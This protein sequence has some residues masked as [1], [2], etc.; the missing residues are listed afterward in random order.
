MRFA[1]RYQPPGA[2]GS[3]GMGSTGV[4][5]DCDYAKVLA[6][7]CATS[8]CHNNRTHIAELILTPD[9]GLIDRIYDVPT[10]HLDID[11]GTNGEYRE[12]DWPS[13]PAACFPFADAL[14]V[15]S[16]NPGDSWL[17]KK[18]N[19]TSGGCGERMPPSGYSLD[20]AERACLE[21]FIRAAAALPR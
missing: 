14:L 1:D 8:G 19:G 21:K 2:A 13:E 5:V 20:E 15:D 7:T 4:V 3:G 17:L 16:R 18:L 11:C 12:C 9:D 10:T 6:D